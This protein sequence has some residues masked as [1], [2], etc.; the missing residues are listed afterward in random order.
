MR[1]FLPVLMLALFP[2]AAAAQFQLTV[3]K[4]M[5]GYESTGHEP[6]NIQFSPDG[7]WIYFR[8][9]PPGTDWR[10][11]LKPYRVRAQ[12]GAVP[13]RLTPAQADSLEPMLADGRLSPDRKRRVVSVRGDLWLVEL[14]SGQLR[15][16]TNTPA[17]DELDP[18]FD[19]AGRRVFFRRDTNIFAL[20]IVQGGVQQITDIRPGPAAEEPKPA[21]GQR[22]ALEREERALL[23]AMRDRRWRDSVDK[24]EREAR[25][26]G[27]I[28]PF[29]LA[30]RA[31]QRELSPSPNGA[32]VLV[33]LAATPSKDRRAGP[34]AGLRD[35]V[36]LHRGDPGPHQ[37]GRLA[38]QAA[39]RDR[40]GEQRRYPLDPAPR[41]RQLRQL[42]QCGVRRV[43]RR[44][45]LRAALCLEPRLHR[46][47]A[48]A[49]RR[50]AGAGYSD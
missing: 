1:R 39:H 31:G 29:Y 41:E 9:L 6:V 49:G 26:A 25:D 17:V 10:E 20:D 48:G 8:W 34:G 42:R 12:A 46:A 11:T 14:P 22:A 40:D 24:A 30:R 21:E 27:R 18:S 45:Q 15:R 33:R 5:R 44:G 43:E 3:P 32:A 23:E 13:E 37:S 4:I 2:P 7:R 35:A 36:R 16:L 38:G 50:G 47:P 28:K 19:S